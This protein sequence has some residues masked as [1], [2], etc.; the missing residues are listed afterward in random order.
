MT[1]TSTPGP[2]PHPSHSH[3]NN[4]N[5]NSHTPT[6]PSSSSSSKSVPKSA[7][8]SASTPGHSNYA[9]PHTPIASAK[10]PHGP[11]SV[12]RS[13]GGN[14]GSGGNSN[15][16]SSGTSMPIPSST[17][18]QN[19]ITMQRKHSILHIVRIRVK[20]FLSSGARASF[21]YHRQRFLHIDPLVGLR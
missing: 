6:P 21:S 13:L 3:N 16:G 4:T 10:W 1:S 14:S 2:Q 12:R 20:M 8:K 11:P 19:T 5:S 18:F 15:G 9:A 7:S 17:I